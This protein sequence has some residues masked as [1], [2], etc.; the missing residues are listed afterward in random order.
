MWTGKGSRESLAETARCPFT[1][2][3]RER[4]RERERERER[5]RNGRAKR[6]LITLFKYP[7]IISD[8]YCC[9]RQRRKTR[10]TSSTGGLCGEREKEREEG[11]KERVGREKAGVRALSTL[12]PI[13]LASHR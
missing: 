3:K 11:R 1:G 8:N 2:R 9:G 13:Y 10:A 6:S 5:E 12:R 7:G 4:K